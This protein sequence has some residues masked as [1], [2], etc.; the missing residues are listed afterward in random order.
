[1]GNDEKCG[2][3]FANPYMKHN[4]CI[5]GYKN[6]KDMIEAQNELNRAKALGLDKGE[7]LLL[8][9][10]LDISEVDAAE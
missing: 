2:I 8:L 5:Y 4:L 3:G 9:A 10:I 7:Y 6:D 1:M